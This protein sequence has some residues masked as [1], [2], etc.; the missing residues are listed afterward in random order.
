LRLF[1]QFILRRLVQE[2]L[3]SCVTVL[4]I[5]LGIA[6]V[7]AIQ[8]ANAS[9]LRGFAAALE[10]I[11]GKTTLEIVGPGVG[12]DE[13]R[14]PQ[15]GW[16]RDYG[17]VSPVIEGEALASTPDGGSEWLHV[18]GV[19][20]LRDRPFRDY[21]LVGSEDQPGGLRLQEFLRLLLQPHSVVL[22]EK[23]ARKHGL[24]VSDRLE[25]TVGDRAESFE[26]SG[27]L[28]NQGPA[29]ALDGNFVLMD[30]AAAQ[31]AFMR[32]GRL[33]RLDVRLPEGTSV[34]AAERA[35]SLRL[36]DGLTAQR[37][38]RRGQQVEK[39]LR[40]FHFNLT[41]LSHIALLVGLFLIY[42]TVSISVITRRREIG[43]L[44]AL[45]L[46]RGRVLGLF[47]AEAGVLAVIGCLSGLLFGRLLAY[48]AVRITS[49]TVNAL[50]IASAAEPVPL[51]LGDLVFAF[52]VGLPLAL[53]AAALPAF[54]A[55]RVPPTAS[56]RGA[57]RLETRYR[58][59]H[60]YLTVPALL[61]G[62]AGWLS[63]LKPVSGVP[64]FGYASAV[65]VVFG[66]AFMV[67]AVLYFV[68]RLSSG[69]LA[70]L[71][72]VEGWLANANLSGAIP[73][74]AVSVAA[75][76][77]S[78]SMMVAVAVMIGSFR[79]TVIYWVGQTL[80]ADLY[81]R[82]STRPNVA[83]EAAVSPEVERV[84][85]ENSWT[86][87]IDLFRSSDLAYE[88]G[89]V[90]VGAGDF[91]VLLEHGN[92]LFKAPENGREAMRSAVGRDAVVV[93]ESFSLKHGKTPGDSVVLPTPKGLSAFRIAAVYY[94]YSSDRGVLV[95]DRSTFARHF[96]EHRPTS[97]SV[98][99][100]K[101]A[102]ANTVRDQILAALGPRYRLF[103]YTN[104]SLRAEVLRIFDSTF[105]VTYAL[106]IVAIFVAILGVAST[107]LTLILERRRE[108]AVLRLIGADRHQVKKMVVIEA[109]LL[110]GVS[111]SIGIA[112][113]VLLSLVLIYVINVQSFGWTI[114]FHLPLGFLAQ[115]SGLILLATALSSLYPA[116][117]ASEFCAAEQVSV[118]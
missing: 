24:S 4:G 32:L 60:R 76:A 20:I 18:L 95:M 72:R 52:S 102:D 62:L 11:S 83:T 13:A 87:A 38:A 90:T 15:L 3:R 40:A 10:T 65:A 77:V 73:R 99:L 56:I 117:K 42:N 64:L 114:Q 110:G 45:G 85:T 34:D 84:V 12:I 5:A 59:Q 21:R 118:E 94:D 55:A 70:R 101:G 28:M 16:L 109:L 53:F 97:L 35:I 17:Q 92:L 54:E 23:F 82:P 36:P 41:A 86:E 50:Y 67:P 33:D 47:L 49:T 26:V 61:F 108:L 89:P 105:A 100:R 25:L 79:E 51:G 71:F 74:I 81:I 104:A 8:L 103:I 46:T 30:I 75:L 1:G 63:S 78:L 6:V 37:P 9:S 93:S 91:A 96:G 106:E 39:M 7:I 113:G 98:Y 69:P 116:R 27:L 115:S 48:G 68:G 14:L 29:R 88:G 111:Q 19:D 31:L 80:Q 43:T 2:K 57:D 66:A 58:L 107:L 22:T 44:R 112:V